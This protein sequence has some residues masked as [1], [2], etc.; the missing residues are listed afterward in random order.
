[1][2]VSNEEQRM[3]AVHYLDADNGERLGQRFEDTLPEI[4]DNVSLDGAGEFSVTCFW[5]LRPDSC[6]V[7]ARR[8][9]AAG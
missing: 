6:D 3:V 1:V 4:G 2:I 5:E 7:Y 8:V 9:P